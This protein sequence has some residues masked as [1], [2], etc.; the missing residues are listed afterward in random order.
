M[1]DFGVKADV[2]HASTP[3]QILTRRVGSG[4]LPQPFRGIAQTRNISCYIRCRGA[5]ASN[6]C[7]WFRRVVNRER[8]SR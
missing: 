4:E 3:R 6:S 1:S 7:T 8:P 2:A 5:A